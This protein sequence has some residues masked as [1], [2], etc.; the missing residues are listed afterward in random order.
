MPH[1]AEYAAETCTPGADQAVLDAAVAL[2]G[3]AAA[4]AADQQ[5]RGQLQ[6]EAAHRVPRTWVPGTARPE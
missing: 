3:T 2:A 6:L 5:L 4:V 1:T